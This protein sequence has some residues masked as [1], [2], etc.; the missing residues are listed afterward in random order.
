[1]SRPKTQTENETE[2]EKSVCVS[3]APA[4]AREGQD[5][6]DWQEAMAE[7][8][9]SGDGKLIAAQLQDQADIP[10]IRDIAAWRFIHAAHVVACKPDKATW[11]FF[12]AVARRASRREFDAWHAPPAPR[13][14][15]ESG[16]TVPLRPPPRGRGVMNDPVIR[17]WVESQG[18]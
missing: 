1:M 7:L 15:P 16:A 11:N 6:A 8:Q 3:P 14:D 9:F 2:I 4:C 5:A 10:S 13:S 18:G 17:A 12:V